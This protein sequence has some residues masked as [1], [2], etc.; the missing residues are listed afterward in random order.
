MRRTGP[1][2][3][4][5]TATRNPIVF[6]HRLDIRRTAC[7]REAESDTREITAARYNLCVCKTNT[8][9]SRAI[10]YGNNT[11]FS[12][13][14]FH[15]HT[16]ARKSVIVYYTYAYTMPYYVCLNSNFVRSH[17][18]RVYTYCLQSVFIAE[19]RQTRDMC[20]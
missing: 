16:Y 5:L 13:S 9:I 6:N 7:A 18:S 14:L 2:Q 3:L 15:A 20:V 10:S 11:P 12:H 17:C 4:S 8:I 19:N 1:L